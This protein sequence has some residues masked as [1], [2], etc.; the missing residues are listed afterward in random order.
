MNTFGQHD[1]EIR[2]AYDRAVFAK[3]KKNRVD[4]YALLGVS[5]ISSTMEIDKAYKI[6]ALT[7]HPDKFAG[8]SEQEIKDAEGAFKL[9]QEAHEILA[10]EPMKRQLYDEGYDKEAID[11]RYERAKRAAREEGRGGHH[12]H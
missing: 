4:Y 1:T 12:H 2:G 11:E 9:L 3:R 8:K 6:K 5:S 10:S 7:C